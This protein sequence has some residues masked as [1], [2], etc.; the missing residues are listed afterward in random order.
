MNSENVLN[1]SIVLAA[2]A[3]GFDP[4]GYH[5][6]NPLQR[7]IFYSDPYV[8]CSW[9]NLLSFIDVVAMLGLRSLPKDIGSKLPPELLPPCKKCGRGDCFY[10]GSLDFS[11]EIND[12]ARY[13]LHLCR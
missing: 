9:C 4:D 10:V 11:A 6:G 2:H 3:A 13:D 8:T 1:R 7:S 5:A 12:R